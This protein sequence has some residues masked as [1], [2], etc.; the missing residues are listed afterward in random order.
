MDAEQHLRLEIIKLEAA[1]KQ[2]RKDFDKKKAGVS[3]DDPFL[4]CGEELLIHIEAAFHDFNIKYFQ[5]FPEDR[6]T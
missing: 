4:K 6:V 3:P 5:L 2:C 1:L